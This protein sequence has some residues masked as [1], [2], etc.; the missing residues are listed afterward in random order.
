M[1]EKLNRLNN[2]LL[3]RNAKLK[4]SND[5]LDSFVYRASHDLRSPLASIMGVI[6]IVKAEK[7]V[8]KIKEYMKYQE[9]SIKKLDDLI[10]DILDLSRNAQLD[11]SMETV[12]LKHLVKNCVDSFSYMD[13]FEKLDIQLLIDDNFI[14]HT[15]VRRLKVIVN[16][17]LSNALHYYDKEKAQPYLNIRAEIIGNDFVIIFQDNGI[18]IHSDHL[19]R[20]FEMFY[21]ATDQNTGSGLGLY[22]VK[23]AIDKLNGV[24][25]LDSVFYKGTTIQM[26]IPKSDILNN[27]TAVS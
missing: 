5:D 1:E 17:L 13:E 26:H 21:R 24:I 15:D 22:I 25:K 4:A 27:E 8:F 19:D 6:N 11:L 14:M 16:N 2:N 23:D 18:G 10:Q 20:V 7:D 9:R 12:N 3:M